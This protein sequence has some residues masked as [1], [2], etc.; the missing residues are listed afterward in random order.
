MRPYFHALLFVAIVSSLAACSSDEPE[1][2]TTAPP[3]A[4]AEEKPAVEAV[5]A[6][7]MPKPAPEGAVTGTGPVV[8]PNIVEGLDHVLTL[9]IRSPQNQA[10]DIYRHPKETL[11]FFG[12]QQKMSV[13]EITPGAG[14]YSEILAPLLKGTGRY[15]AA[16]WDEQVPDQPAYRADLNKKLATLLSTKKYFGQTEVRRFDPRTPSFGPAGSA[17]MV[18]SFRNAHNWIA[19]GTAPAYFKGFADVLKSGGVLGLV[20]HRA[21]PGAATDGKSGYVTEAQI[22]D[23]AIGAGF[24]LADQSEVNANLKDTKDHPEGVWTLPPTLALKDQDRAKYIGIGESDRMTLK[25]LKP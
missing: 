15:I 20:D 17:D 4:A 7:P 18:L 16:V 8:D 1:A 13:I 10:R 14:W 5:Q 22:I 21:A 6:P 9:P 12:L 25:F 3:V 23:L 24:V 11:S 19:D 2:P